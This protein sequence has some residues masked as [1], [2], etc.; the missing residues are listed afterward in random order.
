MSYRLVM[1]H[2]CLGGRSPSQGAGS[3]DDLVFD[4]DVSCGSICVELV[5]VA[6]VV[7]V[8]RVLALIKVRTRS[9]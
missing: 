1:L 2:G 6:I 4:H 7:D 5:A 3:G 9:G 8:N